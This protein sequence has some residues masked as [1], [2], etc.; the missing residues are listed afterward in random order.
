MATTQYFDSLGNELYPLIIDNTLTQLYLETKE[1]GYIRTCLGFNNDT[2]KKNIMRTIVEHVKPISSITI[3]RAEKTTSEYVI[4]F[5]NYPVAQ[6]ADN[7]I[8]YNTFISTITHEANDYYVTCSC[9]ASNSFNSNT[10]HSDDDFSIT[11]QGYTGTDTAFLVF[12]QYGILA[13]DTNNNILGVVYTTIGYNIYDDG[14]TGNY[15]PLG[16]G[17]GWDY[18]GGKQDTWDNIIIYPLG[19]TSKDLDNTSNTTIGGGY[20]SGNNP[21]DTIEIPQLPNLILSNTGSSLYALSS[22]EMLAFSGWLWTSDWTENIKKLRTDPMQNIIGV[23]IIDIPLTGNASTIHVGNL[24]SG[25]NGNL[26]TNWVSVDCGSINV[27]EYYGTFADYEPY[28]ALTLYLPKVG[29]VQIPADAVVNNSIKVVYNV[30]LS[31]GEG[32][33]YVYII[34]NRDNFSYVYNTY[35]CHVSANVALSASDHTQQISAIINASINTVAAVGGA[36]ATGGAT[37]GSAA[38][39]VASS[40]LNVATTKNPTQTKGNFGNFGTLMC[41]KKPYLIINRTNLTK[42]SSFQ[43]NNGYMINYTAK[44]SDHTGFLKTRDFH[45][46]FDAPYSHKAEIER[47]LNEGVFIND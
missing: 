44:I 29:F 24:D 31:S 30:E 4:S 25:V 8:I 9:N 3:P 35:T 18:F 7:D 21:H 32:L 38:T 5:N 36:I 39:T 41:V 45:A 19:Y 2:T 46:E 43:E 26:V 12:K 42:P 17:Y 23:S 22:S 34:N 20:G 16:E 37:T 6:T 11:W 28:I 27:E 10:A 33:C 1:T 14:T 47:M 40:A 13:L 15:K